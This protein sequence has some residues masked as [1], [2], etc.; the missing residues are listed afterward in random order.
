MLGKGGRASQIRLKDSGRKSNKRGLT[1][2]ASR[3]FLKEGLESIGE[4][5]R[6][7]KKK[8]VYDVSAVGKKSL[9]RG[10]E[11]SLKAIP[12]MGKKEKERRGLLFLYCIQGEGGK[13]ISNQ[14]ISDQKKSKGGNRGGKKKEGEH[15]LPLLPYFDGEKGGGGKKRK[16][17]MT[18]ALITSKRKEMGT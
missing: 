15:S 13:E 9:M 5:S 11:E 18:L 14:P 3:R 10:K 6:G 16:G 4:N 1:L 8:G 2:V 17:S 12:A 7:K